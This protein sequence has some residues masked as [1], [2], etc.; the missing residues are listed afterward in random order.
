MVTDRAIPLGRG[1][2]GGYRAVIAKVEG[3]DGVLRNVRPEAPSEPN[4]WSLELVRW[5]EPPL[6]F[7]GE[8]S[9]KCRLCS[10]MAHD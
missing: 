3:I 9:H 10:F 5:A 4:R 1:T 6:E 7:C 2:D 8:P